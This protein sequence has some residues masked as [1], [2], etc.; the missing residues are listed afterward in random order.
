MD[1]EFSNEQKD[2]ITAA[3][4]FAEGEFPEVAEE[5]DANETFPRALGRKPVSWGLWGFLSRKP[6]A[7]RGWGFLMIP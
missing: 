3:R 7:A 5:S 4:E 1:F 6:T 2:I